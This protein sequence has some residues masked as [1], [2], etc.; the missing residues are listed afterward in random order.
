MTDPPTRPFD[1]TPTAAATM[2]IRLER[3][4]LR[5]SGPDTIAF[6]QGQLS[7]DVA[8]LAV[9]TAAW[10]LLLQPQGKVDALLRVLR[11]GEAEVVLDVDGGYGDAVRARLERF[12]LRTRCTLEAMPAWTC[13]A[14]R[15]PGAAEV[16]VPGG[17][18][19]IDPRWPSLEGVD[20]LGEA[21]A[22]PEA[23]PV[24][25]IDAYEALRIEAGVPKL[26]AELTERTIPAEAGRWLIDASVSFTK[27]CYTGQE[28][29]A[30]IDS[31]GGKVARNLRGVVIEG[32]RAPPA[33]AALFAPDGRELGSLTSVAHSSR[34]ASLVALAYVPRAVVPP[35]RALV[36][37]EGAEVG[38][39]VELL[40]L[41]G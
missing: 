22:L 41:V 30:R 29:V 11:L 21:V 8:A 10:S 12:K 16:G 40:P 1:A 18:L 14:V 24:A 7:Q 35:V 9:G 17:V 26:G 13:V 28:L 37:W 34:L 20:L 31:R 39:N 25:E 6:L 23:I 33:G 27:G 38:A 3:D 2:A 32:D 4:A 36:R 15:G 19:A 5:V